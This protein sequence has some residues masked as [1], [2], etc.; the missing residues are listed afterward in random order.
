MAVKERVPEFD[1]FRAQNSEAPYACYAEW[2][3]ASPI[4]RVGPNQW[5][6]A[7]HADV[8]AC[9]KDRRL[10]H[11]M[12]R[13]Y[14]SFVMGDGP[15]GDFRFNSILNQDGPEH[16]RIRRL[17]SQAFTPALVRDLVP[18]VERIVDELIEPLL[19]GEDRDIVDLLA[20]PLPSNVICDLLGIHADRDEVRT[21]AVTLATQADIPASDES[22]I[23]FRE[24]LSAE[25]A[26]RTPDPDGDLL[27]RMLA[28][29]DGDGAFTHEEIVD[30]AVLLFFA[31][32]ET[33]KHLIAN[34]T[35]ALVDFPDQRAM[36]WA[37]PS[38]AM[39]AIEEFLRFDGPVA[40][41]T[42]MAL[43]PIEIGPVV[44][45]PGGVIYQ[46][47][48]AANHDET[49]FDDPERLDITRKPNPHLTFGGGPHRCLGMHLARME[50]ETVFRRL[51]ERLETV[52]G[53]GE[54]ERVAVGFGTW[55]RVP[56]RATAA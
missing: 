50:A 3:R 42:S 9:L 10:V 13:S 56:V 11:G 18:R 16:L 12:P 53:A 20:Y 49:V 7:R 47:L 17:M 35:A 51:A 27:Q 1:I 43:E 26:A 19:D 6:V 55:A 22:T 39:S 31:G 14:V 32:F 36:L 21:R 40:F 52:E 29:E 4:F 46:S 2:R 25:L 44:V 23:W 45:R 5:G 30:N 15:S 41:V 38:L 34:G 37:D 8:E 24:F 48:L 28:A 33:T 54:R